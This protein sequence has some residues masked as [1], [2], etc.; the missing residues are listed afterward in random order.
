[1]GKRIFGELELAILNLFKKDGSTCTVRDVLQ[2]LG[3][4]DK[5]TTWN[6]ASSGI[7]SQ[8]VMERLQRFA[9]FPVAKSIFAP[10]V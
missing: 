6:A 9:K 5:Y 2:S 8:E 10:I 3:R 4:D 7:D 1:M